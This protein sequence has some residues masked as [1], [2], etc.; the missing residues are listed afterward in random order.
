MSAMTAD[1]ALI[2]TPRVRSLA[3]TSVRSTDA[4]GALRLSRRGRLVFLALG[5][6]LAGSVVIGGGWASADEPR[7]AQPVATYTVAA[8]ETLWGIAARIATPAD[9][10]RT[11]VDDLVRLNSLPNAGLHAGQQILVPTAD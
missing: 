9:D 7:E 1:V 5:A 8:G 3:P 6:V 4:G 10:I 2:R 11:I